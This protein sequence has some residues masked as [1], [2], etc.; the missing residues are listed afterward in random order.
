MSQLSYDERDVLKTVLAAG[1]P[2]LARNL[3]MWRDWLKDNQRAKT[4]RN[5]H[6]QFP[7]VL[8]SQMGIYG[9]AAASKGQ[10]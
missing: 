2:N 6:P 3:E 4:N 8:L 5:V 7:L 1:G 9:K 10:S